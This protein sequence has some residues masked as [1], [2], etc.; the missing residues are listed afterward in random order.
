[1]KGIER[2][3]AAYYAARAHEYDRVYEKPERQADIRA[4]REWL[5]PIFEGANAVDVACGTGYWT[6]FIAPAARLTVGID[7]SIETLAI[8]RLRVG[9]NAALV[10]ADAYRLPASGAS[11]DA[12]FVGFWL[13]HIPRAR[14]REFLCELHRVLEPGAVVVIV[15]NRYVEGSNHGIA[16]RDAEGNTYQRRRLE[17]GSV[18]S[19][20]KNFPSEAELRHA[21]DTAGARRIEYRAWD[22]YWALRY[23][24][25]G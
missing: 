14:R 23:T 18:H 4:I 25:G 12:A 9:A 1:V 24:A 22:Y 3:M 5:P 10:V 2:S 11:F 20:L 6:R 21:A 15:D 8:A 16:E 19:V 13:S 17:D 7:A